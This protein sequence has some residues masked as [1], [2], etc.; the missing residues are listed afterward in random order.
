MVKDVLDGAAG[1]AASH[2]S[3]PEP[4]SDQTAATQR[5]ETA[6]RPVNAL[7]VLQSCVAM[8]S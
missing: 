3:A 8:H 6:V 7:V 1:A 2:A 5:S 4:K